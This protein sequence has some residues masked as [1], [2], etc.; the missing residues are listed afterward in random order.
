[1]NYKTVSLDSILRVQHEYEA[2]IATRRWMQN[3]ATKLIENP[4]FNEKTSNIFTRFVDIL[5]INKLD[6]EVA[7]KSIS[8]YWP[9]A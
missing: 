3:T 6:I 7:T 4:I 2:A 5:N 9:G 8:D 1:M